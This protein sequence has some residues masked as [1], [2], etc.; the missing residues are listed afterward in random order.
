MPLE[1][2]RRFEGKYF[3]HLLSAFAVSFLASTPNMEAICSAETSENVYQTT[4]RHI[5]EKN[6]FHCYGFQIKF[7]EG[8]ETRSTHVRFEKYILAGKPEVKKV[9]R[10]P[11]LI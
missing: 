3:L 5:P 2:Y 7:D 10:T 11:K 8:E 4:A 6:I 9:F 1:V